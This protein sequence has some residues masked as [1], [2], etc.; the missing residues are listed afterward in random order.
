MCGTLEIRVPHILSH[1]KNE[2]SE[3]NHKTKNTQHCYKRGRNTRLKTLMKIFKPCIDM[4]CESVLWFKDKQ[5]RTNKGKKMNRTLKN[6]MK[7]VI[8]W[9]KK[10]NDV[11]QGAVIAIFTTPLVTALVI[12]LNSN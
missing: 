2:S 6:D 4:L 1:Q 3:T 7:K 8:A 9:V 12:H 10:L 11:Q 5:R